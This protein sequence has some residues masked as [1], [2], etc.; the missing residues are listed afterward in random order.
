[1]VARTPLADKFIS[2]APFQI[3]DHFADDPVAKEYTAFF[4]FA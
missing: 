4:R 1:M 3:P 2:V